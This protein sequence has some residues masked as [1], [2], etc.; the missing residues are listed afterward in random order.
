MA[1]KELDDMS[2][3]VKGLQT[4][5][6]ELAAQIKETIQT[7]GRAK[8]ANN[9]WI[10]HLPLLNLLAV[11]LSLQIDR[12]SEA[13]LT[14][15]KAKYEVLTKQ[16]REVKQNIRQHTS[17]VD[18]LDL[19]LVKLSSMTDNRLEDVSSGVHI[20]NDVSEA[21][22][23]DLELIQAYLANPDDTKLPWILYVYNQTKKSVYSGIKAA[24]G[25][26]SVS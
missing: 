19:V 6:D 25:N 23:R 3:N 15:M 8:L 2:I 4:Q 5:R 18:E 11:L 14:Q 1:N 7:I 16:I 9:A 24:L 10:W 26:F 20:F 21:G 22:H 17:D 12:E 13:E